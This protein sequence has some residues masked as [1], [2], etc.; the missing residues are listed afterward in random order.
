MHINIKMYYYNFF[1]IFYKNKKIPSAKCKR[2]FN[3]SERLDSN[4][5]PPAPKAGAITGLR[6]AP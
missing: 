2:D 3:V 1:S 4:Q 5:R 6:Y